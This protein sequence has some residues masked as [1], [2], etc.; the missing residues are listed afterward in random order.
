MDFENEKGNDLWKTQTADLNISHTNITVI[1]KT[2]LLDLF[3]STDVTQKLFR[4]KIVVSLVPFRPIKAN[5]TH[6]MQETS[7]VIGSNLDDQ[8]RLLVTF[9]SLYEALVG[10]IIFLDI[11]GST[12]ENLA[13]HF[14]YH[15]KRALETSKCNP[16]IF[17][18]FYETEISSDFIGKVMKSCGFISRKLPVSGCWCVET[19]L[20]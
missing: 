4:E 17:R 9:G 16:L 15:I 11:Y 10:T 3:A 20:H 18:L 12:T 1:D 7:Y 5:V 13:V 6:I 14:R 2:I 19:K 8:D